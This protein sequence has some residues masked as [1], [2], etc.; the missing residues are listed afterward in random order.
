MIIY[1]LFLVVFVTAK[2]RKNRVSHNL[3]VT[4]FRATQ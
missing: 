1:L 3:F 4:T 2:I